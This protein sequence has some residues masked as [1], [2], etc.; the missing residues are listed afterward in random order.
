VTTL[1]LERDLAAVPAPVNA[2]GLDLTHV[3]CCD[4]NRALCGKDVTDTEWTDGDG[5]VT[6]VICD[7]LEGA[8]CGE[9]DC[10]LREGVPT[11]WR[12]WMR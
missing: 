3:V 11:G 1:T 12:R 8:P 5:E 10:P 2:G 9:P 6:C 4:E 7:D